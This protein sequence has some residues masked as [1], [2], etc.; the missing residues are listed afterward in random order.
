MKS[1][2]RITLCAALLFCNGAFPDDETRDIIQLDYSSGNP[3]VEVWIDNKGPYPFLFDTGNIG[4]VVGLE[5]AKELGLESIGVETVS[6]PGNP[7]GFEMPVFAISSLRIGQSQL[8]LNAATGLDFSFMRR[9]ENRPK[10]S[11]S[12]NPGGCTIY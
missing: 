1:A 3:V 6:S 11:A 4:V 8:S 5:L 12:H 10:W 2:R 7:T 9:T